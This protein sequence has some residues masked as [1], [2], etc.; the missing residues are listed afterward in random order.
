MVCSVEEGL[1]LIP[2]ICWDIV[3]ETVSG[4]RLAPAEMKLFT[5]QARRRKGIIG[6]EKVAF[7]GEGEEGLD[8]ELDER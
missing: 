4:A 7:F 5:G 2:D 3:T 6:C 1:E 8:V